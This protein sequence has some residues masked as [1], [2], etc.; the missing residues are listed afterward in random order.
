MVLTAVAITTEWLKERPETTVA[1][2]IATGVAKEED[3][4]AEGKQDLYN[5]AR[6]AMHDPEYQ[7][8]T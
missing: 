2:W 6:Q 3:Y 1:V 4:A 8:M 7:N 5:Q